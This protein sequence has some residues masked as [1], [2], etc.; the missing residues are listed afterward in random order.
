MTTKISQEAFDEAV[1]ENIEEF[2]MTPIEA[3]KETIEQFEAQGVNLS[4]IIKDVK[5]YLP[6]NGGQHEI[7]I[8]LEKL[9][10]YMQ[11]TSRNWS[12]CSEAIDIFVSEC[13]VGMPQ[14][15]LAGKK[16]ALDVIMNLANDVKEDTACLSTVLNAGCMLCDG[17][18]DLLKHEHVSC[19]CDLLDNNSDVKVLVPLIK[20]IRFNCTM[21]EKNKQ[22]FIS[23]D[24][25]PIIT[26]LLSS[27]SYETSILKEICCL[28]QILTLDDDPRVPFSGVHD[29]ARMIVNEKDTLQT[30][31]SLCNTYLENEAILPDL[32]KTLKKLAVR[33]EFCKR[34]NDLNGVELSLSIL[35]G[36]TKNKTLLRQVLNTIDTIGRS[37]EVKNDIGKCG[38]I[39]LILNVMEKYAK[40]KEIAEAGCSAVKVC[41]LRHPENGM[42]VI[43]ASGAELILKI[44]TIHDGTK[45]VMRQ[46]CSAL[47][48]VL[49]RNKEVTEKFLEL[50]ADII[51]KKIYDTYPELRE[52]S[53]LALLDLGA[54]VKLREEWTGRGKEMERD[55]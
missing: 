32:F 53:Q 36:Q 37:D 25:I 51:I 1:K 49:S 27:H 13:S 31:I 24:I 2:E 35:K 6:E 38:G 44:L 7:L 34:I 33:D 42:R 9:K 4:L 14:K 39:E 5:V 10:K 47:R 19:L 11:S 18:P 29:R 50:G 55:D 52:E 20:L 46:G 8:A 21:A 26:N 23:A 15:C 48:N 16:G 17:Y 12:D 43:D 40:V 54:E 22:Y 41:C 45:E 28:F 30:I 3:L